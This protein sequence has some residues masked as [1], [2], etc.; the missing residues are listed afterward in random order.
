MVQAIDSDCLKI[1]WPAPVKI[2]VRCE[3][4]RQAKGGKARD[5]IIA[6]I[7]K[8]AA[9]TNL[10]TTPAAAAADPHTRLPSAVAACETMSYR[11]VH[12]SATLRHGT[13]TCYPS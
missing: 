13:L 11:R 10:T 9:A 12:A 7:A 5:E 1:L 6:T 8:S 4:D 2:Q 3:V